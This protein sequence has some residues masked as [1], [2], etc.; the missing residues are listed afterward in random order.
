MSPVNCPASV[1]F[2]WTSGASSLSQ[3]VDELSTRATT[4]ASGELTAETGCMSLADT[5]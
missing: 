2:R 4:T 3:Q 1:F 5:D